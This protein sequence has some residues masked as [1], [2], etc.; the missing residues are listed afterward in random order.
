MVAL[1]LILTRFGSGPNRVK[2]RSKSGSEGV[3]SRGVGP[4]DKAL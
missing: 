4:A 3:G 1:D 2:I